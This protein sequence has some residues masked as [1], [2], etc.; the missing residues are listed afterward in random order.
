MRY[1]FD[2]TIRESGKAWSGTALDFNDSNKQD[3]LYGAFCKIRSGA[4]Q[5]AGKC[6]VPLVTTEQKRHYWLEVPGSESR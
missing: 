5:C 6:D 3:C 2:S 4:G 1:T